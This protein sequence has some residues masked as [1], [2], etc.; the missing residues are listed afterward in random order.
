MDKFKTDELL[1][2]YEALLQI[3]P[4]DAIKFLDNYEASLA[5]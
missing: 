4:P 2:I 1:P 5:S 3:S